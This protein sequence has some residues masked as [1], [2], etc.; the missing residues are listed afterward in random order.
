[1]SAFKYFT[2]IDLVHAQT[3]R[4]TAMPSLAS[5]TRKEVKARVATSG[6]CLPLTGGTNN[7]QWL[8]SLQVEPV[9]HGV[10]DTHEC[11]KLSSS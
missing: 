10:N 8:R 4:A 2:K 5:V 9:M 11:W 7:G 1:M 3:V 6:L